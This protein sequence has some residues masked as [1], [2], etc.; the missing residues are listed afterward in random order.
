MSDARTE[1]SAAEDAAPNLRYAI[2][3][4]TALMLVNMFI[5]VD[6]QILTVLAEDI[7]AD[8]KLSDAQIG[9]VYGTAIAVFYAIFS[10]PF[11]R[12]ADVWTR[13]NLLALCIAIWSAMIFLTG[14]ARSLISFAIF[15]G[16]VGIGE[17]GGSPAI[18]S[19]ITDYFPP[20]LRATAMSLFSGG[21]MLGGGLGLYLGGLILDTW[22]GAY[23]D[24][25]L[26]PFGL[27]GW[28]VAFFAVAIPG[29][30]LAWWIFTLRE[31][32]RGQ[33][34]GLSMA[35][36]PQPLR[37]VL[38][39]LQSVLPVTSL[40]MMIRR[41]A[42]GGTILL[43]LAIALM[44]A[45]AAYFLTATTGNALQWI[46]LG[47]GMYCMASWIQ[48][49]A[50]RDPIS[51]AMIFK[52]P[53]MTC[54]VLGLATLYFIVMG[55]TAW[56]VPFMIRVHGVTASEAGLVVGML[57]FICGFCGNI[58]SGILADALERRTPR[59]R[60][61]VLLGSL[62]TTVP[63][64]VLLVHVQDKRAA[65]GLI[66]LFYFAGMAWTGVGPAVVNSLVM[67]R[68]RGVSSAFYLIALTLF[69]VALGPYTMGYVS[70][71]YAAAGSGSGNALR[72][73]IL[74]GLA[75]AIPSVALLGIAARTIAR[76]QAGRLDRARAL[77]EPV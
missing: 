73:G 21:M 8:L 50:L 53:S 36:H 24:P 6:R 41:G 5:L 70:D 57:T 1:T 62:V 11:G 71:I 64:V 2:Y 63:I 25:S 30:L 66:G 7:K 37:E 45:A 69:G 49:L 15:R 54:T 39:E 4:L 60:A 42:P 77:G 10:I 68:M 26:T 52:C 13:K 3:V 47:I 61:Y 48:N 35:A 14:T 72:S 40:L 76:D 28:Q 33:S 17:A 58:G 75:M 29:P 38:N 9:F 51:F 32:I 18:F 31:P 12:A 74:W 20:R 16:G 67:P 59:G 46:S 23:P 43:N 56:T 27:R 65:Y 55:V 22:N 44:I 34:E 19:I